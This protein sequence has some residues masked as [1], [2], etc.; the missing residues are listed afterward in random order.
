VLAFSRAGYGHNTLAALAADTAG[1]YVHLCSPGGL[2]DLAQG[3][4]GWQLAPRW[5][6]LVRAAADKLG[7]FAE[8]PLV[9]LLGGLMARQGLDLGPLYEA[10]Q[11][12]VC[13]RGVCV[14]VCGVCVLGACVRLLLRAP[15]ARM[16]VR[17]HCTPW[18]S[19]GRPQAL[20]PHTHMRVRVPR[21]VRVHRAA[22]ADAAHS[23]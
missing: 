12:C 15:L 13:V 5:L 14:C 6:C 7:W 4:A 3:F 21:V 16:L 22:G 17:A 11:V 10:A 2:A 18:A 1:S 23:H 9:R 19:R 20:V 8:G